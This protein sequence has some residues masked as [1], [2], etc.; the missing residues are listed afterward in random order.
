MLGMCRVINLLPLRVLFACCGGN[1]CKA[2][3]VYNFKSMF[4]VY[5]GRILNRTHANILNKRKYQI[6]A[7]CSSHIYIRFTVLILTATGIKGGLANPLFKNSI[8]IIIIIYFW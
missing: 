1:D 4:V 6:W 8:I 3:K 5:V 7:R 2:Y